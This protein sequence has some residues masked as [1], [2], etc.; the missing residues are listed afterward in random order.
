MLP[1]SPA[2]AGAEA[3]EPPA[4]ADGPAVT[5]ADCPASIDDVELLPPP[6]WTTPFESDALLPLPDTPTGNDADAAEP[7]SDAPA[8]GVAEAVPT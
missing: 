1:G 6:T 7:A 8:A 5:A 3:V 4:L 2:D